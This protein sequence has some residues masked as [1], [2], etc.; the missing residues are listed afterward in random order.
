MT[1]PRVPLVRVPWPQ[2]AP[3]PRP[4]VNND[5]ADIKAD[6]ASHQP[7]RKSDQIDMEFAGYQIALLSGGIGIT[8]T[9]L[10]NLISHRLAIR[11]IRIAAHMEAA[12]NL[13]A[14]LAVPLAA[15]RRELQPSA[16][17]IQRLLEPIIDALALQMEQFRFHLDPKDIAAYDEACNQYQAIARIRAM[18]Y[19]SLGGKE[20]LKVFEARTNT[21]L[22][23]TDL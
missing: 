17:N 5:E 16:I 6:H 18:N 9:L 10:G 3:L 13:R 23:F 11:L 2:S 20:P 14:A 1:L 22:H 12:N 7:R 15:V 8:G 4:R 21:V 19:E